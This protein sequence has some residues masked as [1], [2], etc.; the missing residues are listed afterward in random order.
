MLW[1]RLAKNSPTTDLYVIAIHQ[2]FLADSVA[3]VFLGPVPLILSRGFRYHTYVDMTKQRIHVQIVCVW[4]LCI[5][6]MTW[7][8]VVMT[9]L[10]S[11]ILNLVRL[12]CLLNYTCA[13]FLVH[14]PPCVLHATGWSDMIPKHPETDS[15]FQSVVHNVF[16]TLSL[17]EGFLYD[18]I[19]VVFTLS[20]F[21]KGCFCM[22]L[23]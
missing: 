3:S 17:F 1:Y 21:E 9:H 8:L 18:V 20:L 6:I 12:I 13:R 23:Y 5:L 15:S 22:M 7:K 14:L 10:V 2:A 16:F 4:L 11:R 19:L